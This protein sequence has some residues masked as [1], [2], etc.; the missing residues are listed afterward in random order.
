MNKEDI[1]YLKT[2]NSDILKCLKS[3]QMN[4]PIF[5]PIESKT[6]GYV[7]WNDVKKIFTIDDFYK[8]NTNLTQ[9]LNEIKEY[10]NSDKLL[11]RLCEPKINN[12]GETHFDLIKEDILKI[13]DKYLGDSDEKT[14]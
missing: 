2:E 8:E 4:K 9:A 7:D 6:N 3:E 10:V 13:I 14:N 1:V 11:G 12:K 5:Y